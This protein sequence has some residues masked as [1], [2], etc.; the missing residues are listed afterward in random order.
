MVDISPMRLLEEDFNQPDVELALESARHLKTVGIALGPEKTDSELIPFLAQFGGYGPTDTAETKLEKVVSDEVLSTIAKE[1]GG[2]VPLSKDPCGL[3]NLLE[4]LCST[5]ETCIWRAAV[6]SFDQ[7]IRDLGSRA[8]DLVLPVVKS[9]ATSELFSSRCSASGVIVSLYSHCSL[10]Q[11]KS[12]LRDYI[13]LLSKDEAPLV[14]KCV[15]EGLGHLPSKIG[16]DIFNLELADVLQRL[17]GESQEN[18]R[19]LLVDFVYTASKTCNEVEFIGLCL[20]QIEFCS[21]ETSWRIRR[22]LVSRFYDIIANVPSSTVSQSLLP[23]YFGFL[24][25]AEP[26]VRLSALKILGGVASIADT[27]EFCS[28]LDGVVD[29]LFNDTHN[30]CRVAF[31]DAI[32]DLCPIVGGQRTLSTLSPVL[33]KMLDDDLADTRLN[34]LEK[35]KVLVDAI[36]AEKVVEMFVPSMVAMSNDV[37]WRVRKSVACN[38]TFLGETVG[39]DVYNAKFKGILVRFLRDKVN[40]VRLS[41]AEQVPKLISFFGLDWGKTYLLP[42]IL[43]QFHAK[44]L[45]YLRRTVPLEVIANLCANE[46]VDLD[47]Q[48]VSSSLMPIVLK[49]SQDSIANGLCLLKCSNIAS[50]NLCNQSTAGCVFSCWTRYR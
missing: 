29:S 34:V 21:Q 4:N 47:S 49:A 50:T 17:R 7:V 38:L 31:S 44:D 37:K 16:A 3:I 20:P 39:E 13:V 41:A 30:A 5:P 11:H 12:A 23:L 45:H 15:F 48:Y 25:D 27:E 18:I 43:Q 8:Q 9:L 10:E 22:A 35:L 6:T 32:L 28:S 40:E 19:T 2:F 14:R 42:E 46:K 26:E 24:Q 36:G 1:L 33:V